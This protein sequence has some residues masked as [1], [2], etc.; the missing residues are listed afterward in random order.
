ML[1]IW[2]SS[3][4]KT[5]KRVLGPVISQHQ[6]PHKVIPEMDTIPALSDGDVLL[7]M[8]GK[9]L[10]PLI[11]AGVVPKNRTVTS[12]RSG[13][14]TRLVPNLVVTYDPGITE[15]E[16]TYLPEIQ[17]DCQL[18]IRIHSTGS[19][20]PKIG[21]Y[22]Y[23]ES[24]HELIEEVEKRYERTKKAVPVASDLE[25]LGLDEYN[26]EGWI[27]ADSFTIDPGKAD[28]LYFERGETP[29][30]PAPWTAEEDM[31][32]WELLWVQIHW[33]YTSPKVA[34]R[35]AN[36]KYDSRWI[37]RK[38]DIDVVNLK[39]DTFL[40]GALLD[41]NRSNSLKLHAKVYTELGGYEDD[42][43]GKYDMG[44][45]DLVPKA[46]LLPY[47][48]GDTDSTL[49]VSHVFKDELFKDRALTH[50]YVNLLHPSSKVFE[51]M[52]RTGIVVDIPYYKALESELEV[53]MARLDKEMKALIPRKLA[54]KYQDNFSLTR[55]ALLREY[56]FTPAGL[57]LKPSV[58]TAKANEASTAIDH[59]LTFEDNPAAMAFI[60][61]LKESNSASK[62]LS[63]FV[64]GFMKHL[65]SDGRFH[66]AY[67]LARGGFD[68]GS[69]DEGT[70]TG[71]TSA[72]DPAVQCLVGDSL[73]NTNRGLVTIEDLIA[74]FEDGA[75]YTVMTHTGEWNR[76]VGTYRNGLQPVFKITTNNGNTLTCT[77]NHPWLTSAG[78]VKASKL[79]LGHKVFTTRSGDSCALRP[80]LLAPSEPPA[81]VKK[82][83]SAM[84]HWW[85][86]DSDAP[87]S[88]RVESGSSQQDALV[89]GLSGFVLSAINCI[90]YIGL[91][92][93]FDITIENAHSF[94]ANNCVVHNT[95]PKHTKWTKKLRRV[96]VPP[97]GK[98]ILQ[99]D[100]SQGELKIAAC[101]AEEP[102]M[103]Q[104]YLNGI[105]LHAVTAAQLNGYSMDEFMLLPDEV[106]DDLRSGG[107]AGN[108]GL[109][110]GMQA[111]GFQSYAW[112]SYGVKMTEP[113]A[114]VKREAFF[115]LYAE[116]LKW[117]EGYKNI[118]RRT[119]QIRSPL[120]RIRHLPLINSSNREARSQAER[121]AVNSPVQATLSDMMQLA[122]ILIDREYGAKND[123]EMFLMTHDSCAFYVPA[124]D[125]TIWAKRLKGIM[126][127]LPL[128]EMFG[129]DHQ[130]PFTTD[131][132]VSLP[133]ADGVMSLATLKKLKNL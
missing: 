83:P 56:L 94:I 54:L 86:R 19:P 103:L 128:R 55:P 61:L 47:V 121:Q 70:V 29:R 123:V 37:H 58:F 51:K 107:K 100:Y 90:Q 6:I 46:E 130:L 124:E 18:A 64:R 131:A 105:D 31:E 92:E 9:A 16:Y 42:M 75:A 2:T 97:P 119:G 17:W 8:G 110:Y 60:N 62:T 108:F 66:P 76:V 74:K 5:I 115:A 113:E 133:D 87:L 79:R 102:T 32:Y 126:D 65:R 127:N 21:S 1:Y 112:N 43:K 81:E 28:V 69:K 122:M 132:E 53:E 30:P 111:A 68:G 35:G 80:G 93:T 40:V 38:W 71:R 98:T 48:G 25:T 52:E 88:D 23:V 3:D 22:R 63:T 67:R 49:Q 104:S 120:G 117:H 20:Q 13:A 50:F 125:A 34:L 12:L 7:A 89:A 82:H 57:N 59:L 45:L 106:R 36:F 129:W 116:L 72:T 91:R 96:Y 24:L 99:I 33:L 95:I 85:W 41:E 39:M 4:A 109:I 14:I 101:L 11:K 73:I 77:G 44:R 27:I 114:V 118:A 10:D 26:P 84:D 15:K 78:F